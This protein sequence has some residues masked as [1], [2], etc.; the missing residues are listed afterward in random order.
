MH[1]LNK[2]SRSQTHSRS[3]SM[4]DEERKLTQE[5]LSK[6]YSWLESMS[7]EERKLTQESRLRLF[8]VTDSKNLNYKTK[9]IQKFEKVKESNG[10]TKDYS[11]GIQK[12]REVW[13]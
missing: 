5:S 12:T 10:S 9:N 8:N 2:E 13:A 4:S 7:D 11:N 1:Y 6:T 3:E